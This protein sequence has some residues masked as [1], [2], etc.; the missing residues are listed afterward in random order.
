MLFFC[1]G[2]LIQSNRDAEFPLRSPV[3]WSSVALDAHGD[4]H[5]AADAQGGEA[6]LGVA[7][8]HFIQQ[9]HQHAGA[10]GADRMADGNGAAV[11][12]HLV[13]IPAHV[14]S[15]E[16]TSELTSLMRISYAVF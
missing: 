13:G 16:H 1:P 12:V 4:A 7:A 6:F 5:A 10:R 2:G 11:D 8:L 9:G 14:R 3:G 15:E